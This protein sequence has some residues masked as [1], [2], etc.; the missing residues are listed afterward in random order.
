MELVKPTSSE[1]IVPAFR[2]VGEPGWADEVRTVF[3][4]YGVPLPSPAYCPTPTEN[5]KNA[6]TVLPTVTVT[7]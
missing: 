3:K 5:S 7:Q 6:T 4:S 2:R 1:D